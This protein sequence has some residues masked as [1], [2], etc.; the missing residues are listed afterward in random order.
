MFRGKLSIFSC[1]ALPTSIRF[2][3]IIHQVRKCIL[4]LAL[5]HRANI[6]SS[7]LQH[8]FWHVFFFFIP[9]SPGHR[10]FFSSYQV[11]SSHMAPSQDTVTNIF[12]DNAS[13]NF[14]LP[15][16][17]YYSVCVCVPSQVRWF[18][19]AHTVTWP[20]YTVCPA[21]NRRLHRDRVQTDWW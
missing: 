5:T 3:W 8:L 19:V 9:W 13:M 14:H 20:L 21:I 15:V 6:W 11:I 10:H 4:Y 7:K 17:L 2:C 1:V 18:P 16:C 12:H